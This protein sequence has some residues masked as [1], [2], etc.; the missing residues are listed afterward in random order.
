MG[1][2]GPGVGVG[3]NGGNMGSGFKA[4]VRGACGC[5][6]GLR[7]GVRVRGVGVGIRV[8]VLGAP[9]PA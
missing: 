2:M 8:W 1:C 7:R 5:G 4:G 9:W 3:W 6:M